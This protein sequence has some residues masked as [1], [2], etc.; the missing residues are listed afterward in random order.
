MGQ[1][2]YIPTPAGNG[3]RN[4]QQCPVA[5]IALLYSNAGSLVIEQ[6][7]LA[8]DWNPLLVNGCSAM[9]STNTCPTPHCIV[10]KREEILP[11][12]LETWSQRR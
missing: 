7:L 4:G 3:P 1:P 2:H 12:I 11:E 8:K 10:G 9:M 5:C 6:C